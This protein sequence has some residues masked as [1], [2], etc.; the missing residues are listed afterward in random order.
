MA[1]F[2][3]EEAKASSFYQSLLGENGDDI[4]KN[5]DIIPIYADLAVINQF[6]KNQEGIDTNHA[7][8]YHKFFRHKPLNLE[9]DKQTIVGHITN[10]SFSRYANSWDNLKIEDL[11][12]EVDPF[13]LCFAGVI[14]SKIFPNVAGELVSNDSPSLI[15]YKEISASWEIGFND[16]DIALGSNN[17]SECEVIK[18]PEIKRNYVQYL[19][20]A[21]GTGYT[22]DNKI[23]NRLLVGGAINNYRYG[24]NN[25]NKG[26]PNFLKKDEYDS[27]KISFHIIIFTETYY[28]KTS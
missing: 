17:L 24:Y 12:G 18:D 11:L 25:Y 19:K 2:V 27:V 10:T 9:H 28:I 20:K 16:F 23:V 3:K 6:N 26:S 8:K 13:Y 4:A 5:W 21:G 14:Y 22:K 1:S 7:L 15:A